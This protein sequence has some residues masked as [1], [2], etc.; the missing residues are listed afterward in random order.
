MKIDEGIHSFKSLESDTIQIRSRERVAQLGEVFTADR[1]IQL[2][3]D[4]WQ[5]AMLESGSDVVNATVLEPSCGNCRF[6]AELLRRKFRILREQSGPKALP[7]PRDS[8]I[9]LSTLYGIDISQENIEEALSVLDECWHDEIE[10]YP[11]DIRLKLSEVGFRVLQS[12]LINS[13]FLNPEENR[14]LVERR[15]DLSLGSD[16][17]MVLELVWQF[18]Q[19]LNPSPLSKGSMRPLNTEVTRWDKVGLFQLK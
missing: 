19:V 15:P 3:V 13:D 7:S 9:A 6:L 2:M 5:S 11:R 16:E 8:V 17:N 4:M 1:E 18:D 12:N 14:V 10:I